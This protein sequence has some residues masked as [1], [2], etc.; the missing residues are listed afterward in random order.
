MKKT[1]ALLLCLVTV[2]T[3]FI[4]CKRTPT[5]N[6]ENTATPGVTDSESP[7]TPPSVSPS[8]G[9]VTPDIS[10][11]VPSSPGTVTPKPVTPTPVIRDAQKTTICPPELITTGYTSPL[12]P[13]SVKFPAGYN[14]PYYLEVDVINQC[15]NVFIKNPETGA[16]DI[17][18]NR[19]VTSGGTSDKPTL[20]GN[21]FIRTQAE[22]KALTGQNVKEYR[23]YFKKYDSYAY[24]VTRY[25]DAY[26][27]HSFT[28]AA[29]GG[30]I[31]AK[32]GAYYNMGNPGS[33][34]CLRMLMGHAKWIWDNI[35]G[36]T[37]CVVTKARK[38]DKALKKALKKYI[39]PMGYDM[40]SSWV[41]G[42]NSKGLTPVS[43]VQSP[44]KVNG[45]KPNITPNPN[46]TPPP[47]PPEV[48]PSPTSTPSPTPKVTPS[49]S[50][51]HKVTPS[52][53]PKVTPSPT[54]T[55]PQVTTPA[56]PETTTPAPP[57][58]TTPAPESGS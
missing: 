22:Q 56:P 12:D 5:S 21:F 25:K 35:D 26:M 17:L 24:Y 28:F 23:Y 53:T 11:A 54:P 9:T 46:I 43:E 51:T 4:G 36:G 39:P 40:T 49:P 7:K 31:K 18:L 14:K 55:A 44:Q 27:F 1:A 50:P 48:T 33:A 6:V 32:T 19:F 10:P 13:A 3:L 57:Q 37:Y 2:S 29:S 20:T 41:P 8:G 42:D 38:T 47:T 34:G 58:T 15:V 45:S 30:Y 16:Y 52:P